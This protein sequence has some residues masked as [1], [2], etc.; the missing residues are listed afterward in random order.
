MHRSPPAP[1]GPPPHPPRALL[2]PSLPHP[3]GPAA[4]GSPT[5][6]LQ[7]GRRH[8]HRHCPT[9][10]PPPAAA[11]AAAAGA[12]R[13]GSPPWWRRLARA[14]WFRSLCRSACRR[15]RRR[16]R[17][18]G[19]RRRGCPRPHLSLHPAAHLW[20]GLAAAVLYGLAVAVLEPRLVELTLRRLAWPREGRGGRSP[21]AGMA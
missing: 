19:G 13:G 3:A 1:K 5:P 20:F 4:C 8:R 17:S 9:R 12:C 10:W 18:T 16:A 11:A 21:K 15:W 2:P 7:P 14:S 6:L